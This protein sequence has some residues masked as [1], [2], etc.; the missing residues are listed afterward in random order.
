M[1]I[2]LAYRAPKLAR[3]FLVLHNENEWMRKWMGELGKTEQFEMWRRFKTP[4]EDE[5]EENEQGVDL[6]G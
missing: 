4:P 3:A 5:G 2:R 6:S 1:A